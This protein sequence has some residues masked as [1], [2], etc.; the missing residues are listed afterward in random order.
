[1]AGLNRPNASGNHSIELKFCLNEQFITVKE[2]NV[3]FVWWKCSYHIPILY[4]INLTFDSTCAF[5]MIIGQWKWV[6]YMDALLS[7]VAD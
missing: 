3:Y 5:L 6:I 2:K 4:F 7:T 1:M